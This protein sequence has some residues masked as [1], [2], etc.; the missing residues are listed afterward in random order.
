MAIFSALAPIASDSHTGAMMFKVSSARQ[1]Q[2]SAA[3]RIAT[4]PNIAGNSHQFG[5]I[6]G[7]LARATG[8][9]PGSHLVE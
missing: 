3:E 2:I 7:S 5:S 9:T 4:S 1:S 8:R 6:S